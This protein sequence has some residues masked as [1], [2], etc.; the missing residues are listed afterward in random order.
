MIFLS[1]SPLSISLLPLHCVCINK[2][3]LP[4]ICS[5]NRALV[6]S[7]IRFTRVTDKIRMFLVGIN[8]SDTLS[9]FIKSI[10]TRC[11]AAIPILPTNSSYPLLLFSCLQFAS[12]QN[13][14]T[15][16]HS[17]FNRPQS[18]LERFPH[19]ISLEPLHHLQNLK[20]A[21]TSLRM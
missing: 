18:L 15:L 21:S 2:K 14:N 16:L 8:A 1:P 12:L 7:A 20:P 6:E 13:P 3:L 10:K 4:L 19:S 9:G 11:F 17:H 5:S